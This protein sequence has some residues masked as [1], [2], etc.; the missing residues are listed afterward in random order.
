MLKLE[1][2]CT[3]V[4]V[5]VI[6]YQKINILLRNCNDLTYIYD[7]IYET[8]LCQHYNNYTY[9]IF[10]FHK[11]VSSFFSGKLNELYVPIYHTRNT[12]YNIVALSRVPIVT[13]YYVTSI[14]YRKRDTGSLVSL[15]RMLHCL[16]Q[17]IYNMHLVSFIIENVN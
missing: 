13:C 10:N 8:I 11:I 7:I 3:R 6:I 9:K 15:S 5:Y 4:H 1:A 17:S 14:L 12:I 16:C 2:K